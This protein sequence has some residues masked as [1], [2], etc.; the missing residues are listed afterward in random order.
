[1]VQPVQVCIV[2]RISLGGVRP[3]CVFI[4]SQARGK[5]ILCSHSIASFVILC[6]LLGLEFVH[7]WQVIAQS[8]AGSDS[9]PHPSPFYC[10]FAVCF[11]LIQCVPVAGVRNLHAR[12]SRYDGMA[13]H[14]LLAFLRGDL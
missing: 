10:F 5:F 9:P 4:S 3:R 2:C 1:M 6:C 12:R 13:L 7:P 14:F 11:S 8:C